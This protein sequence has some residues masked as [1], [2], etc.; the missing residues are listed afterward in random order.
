MYVE[1]VM[2]KEMKQSIITSVTSENNFLSVGYI[3]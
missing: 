1:D 3:Q 2:V